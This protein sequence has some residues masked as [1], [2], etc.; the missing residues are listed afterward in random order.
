LAKGEYSIQ[1]PFFALFNEFEGQGD[2]LMQAG[3]YC[4]K[5]PPSACPGTPASPLKS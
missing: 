1:P 4:P 5:V 2:Q 3:A